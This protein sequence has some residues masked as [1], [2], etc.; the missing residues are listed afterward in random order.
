MLV[1]R[2][3]GVLN[4]AQGAIAGVGGY[5]YYEFHITYGMPLALAIV[6]AVALCAVVGAAIHFLVMRPL[7][8]APPLTRVI[9]ALG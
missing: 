7:S 5:A 1:Y 3:S 6:L 9:A 4:F 8:A 2:G